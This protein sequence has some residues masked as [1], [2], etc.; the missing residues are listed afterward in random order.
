MRSLLWWNVQGA[1]V[2]SFDSF[3]LAGFLKRHWYPLAAGAL[4]LLGVSLR[5]A[6]IVIGWPHSNSEEGA[7][8]LEAMHIL[9]RGERPIYFYGQNYMGVGEAYLGAL[10]FRLLGVSVASL[11]LGMVTLYALFMIGVFWLAGLL[12]SRRVALASLAALALGSPFIVQ[13]ELRADGGKI[14]TMAFGALMF[15]LASWLALSRPTGPEPGKRR[16][17]RPL[18]FVAWGLFAGLGLYTYAIVAPFVLTSGLLLGIAC[19]RELRGWKLALPL[20]G[21][22]IGLLPAILYAVTVSA[23]D[24]PISVFLSLHQSLNAKGAAGENTLLKQVD[25][26]LLY[27]LPTVTGLLNL[28]PLHALPLYGPPDRA[29]I[30]AVVIGG[31][32]SLGYLMLLGIATARPL[33]ALRQARALRRMDKRAQGDA[34]ADTS[35]QSSNMTTQTARDMARLL[36]ALTAWLTIAAYM[37]SATAANNP[38]SG[39]YMAGLLA[40]TPA[41]LWPLMERAERAAR[42]KAG[43][44]TRPGGALPRDGWRLAGMALLGVSLALGVVGVAQSIPDAV[45]ANGRDARFARALLSHGVTR[46]YSDYWT[47]NLLTFETRERLICGVINDYA[48]PGLTR[49]QPYY[50]MVRADP[51]APYVLAH[52]SSIERTFLIYAAQNHQRYALTKIAGHDVY[53]PILP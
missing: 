47:C 17:L 39:R 31:G 38:Y 53:T 30:T 8:G 10:A 45:A 14:E 1:R 23:A 41:L 42:G 49:Y 46:F 15:A 3:D 4:I 21:L 35:A 22:L 16:A 51:S 12:Y 9:L 43:L 44:A 27:T 11:R 33:G 25:A 20:A 13:L 24:N 32:W 34:L 36:L 18:A 6:L 7:M 5:L 52:G 40:I 26:T 28:Y 48:K 29:T 37:F 19:W 50:E 2:R